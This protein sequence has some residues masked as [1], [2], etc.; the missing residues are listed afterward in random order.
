M[1]ESDEELVERHRGLVESIVRTLQRQLQT[2][3][4]KADLV[5]FA[6]LGLIEARSRYDATRGVQF[7]TFAYYRIRGA[8]IDGIGQMSDV[9][10]NA[11]RMCKTLQLL[12]AESER[13]AES[14]AQQPATIDVK[15]AAVD[16][17]TTLMSRTAAGHALALMQQRQ[18][19]PEEEALDKGVFEAVLR[20]VES[21]PEREKVLIRGHYIAERNLDEVGAELGLSKS[22]TS[23]LHAK[24][25][26]RI[27][28]ALCGA[29]P[30]AGSG[31]S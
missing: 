19:S 7:S 18:R 31:E 22:W 24:A 9:P 3:V 11:H 27:R 13:I 25:L 20:V 5:A 17:L 15:Q 14:R 4:P 16:S 28:A 12:D 21:L 29:D 8:V 1:S 30:A 26:D 10:R 6:M 2:S 23:R